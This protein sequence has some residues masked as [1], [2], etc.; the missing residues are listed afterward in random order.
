ME[1][2]TQI[3]ACAIGALGY[4]LMY[5]VKKD[6]ILVATLGGFFTITTYIISNEILDNIFLATTLASAVITFYSEILARKLK[7]P[8]TV[9]LLPGIIPLVP[10][11]GL[12]YTMTGLLTKDS[13]TFMHYGMSTF[14]TAAGIAIGVII[15]SLLVQHINTALAKKANHI[16]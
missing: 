2:I 9:F 12:F 6:K 4:A 8:A 5:N 16:M 3:I 11:G 1:H 7:S 10:G 14:E 13:E 15:A